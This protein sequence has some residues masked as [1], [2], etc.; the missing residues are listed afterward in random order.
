MGAEAGE[1]SAIAGAGGHAAP[2]RLALA[3]RHTRTPP[4]GLLHHHAATGTRPTRPSRCR[5]RSDLA[6][7]RYGPA[8]AAAAHPLQLGPPRPRRPPL[9]LTHSAL[10]C[11]T[12]VEQRRCR[13]TPLSAGRQQFAST[14]PPPTWA[15]PHASTGGSA[16][17][18]VESTCKVG[19]DWREKKDWKSWK[20]AA[21]SS[22]ELTG[23]VA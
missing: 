10:A 20:H 18:Q 3:H 4:A 12:A 1:A 19:W 23:C 6:G 15:L 16:C 9:E 2:Q 21:W 7:P 13:R 22:A 8:G 5:W 17:L 11:T 14:P